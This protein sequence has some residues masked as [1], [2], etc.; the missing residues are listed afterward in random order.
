MDSGLWW[1][2]CL[3][4]W[5]G[6]TA[7]NRARRSHGHCSLDEA[8][9]WEYCEMLSL[10]FSNSV[11]SDSLWPH[12]LQHARLPCPSPSPQAC[13]NICPLSRWCHPTVSSSVIPF[14]SC[15]QSFPAS[16]SFPMSPLFESG[17]QS[18]GASASA[19]TL[20][21][22]LSSIPSLLSTYSHN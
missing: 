8:A 20:F 15:F 21:I 19:K 3:D 10:L 18:I 14:S 11:V 17:G 7:H 4:S 13:L 1:R 2:S 9:P 5:A 12:G 16:G 6:I 22:F